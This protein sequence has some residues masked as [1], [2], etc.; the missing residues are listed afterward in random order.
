M[1]LLHIGIASVVLKL[2][3]LCGDPR[4]IIAYLIGLSHYG[5]YI[6]WYSICL[7]KNKII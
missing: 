5:E 1:V 2:I 4:H 7:L 6:K 3:L